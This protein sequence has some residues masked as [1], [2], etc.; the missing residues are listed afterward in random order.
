MFTIRKNPIKWLK[1][2][3]VCEYAIR[4]DECDSFQNIFMGFNEC[5]AAYFHKL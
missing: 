2:M 3:F 4:K 5:Y 1:N